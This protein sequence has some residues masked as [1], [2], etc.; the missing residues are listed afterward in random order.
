M[1]NYNI[2][3]ITWSKL[4]D[5]NEN[6]AILPAGAD[7]VITNTYQASI[8]GFKSYLNLDKEE[9]IELIKESVNYVKKAI[10]L[11][12]GENDCCE[13]HYYKI[14][15]RMLYCINA[16]IIMNNF[17]LLWGEA[18]I[19]WHFESSLLYFYTCNNKK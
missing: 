12:L 15:K 6:C 19:V 4:L 18:L 2:V 7:I 1:L 9:S 11:E 13:Y 10:A 17:F 5:F 16:K 3:S 8:D 14:R